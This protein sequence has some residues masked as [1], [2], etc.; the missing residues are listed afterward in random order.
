MQSGTKCGRIVETLA[1]EIAEGRY[2][3]PSSF[4]SAEQIVR[5]FKVAY[6]TAVKAHD[7]LKRRGLV[8]SVQG[9]GTYVA[10][11]AGRSVGLVVPG[12]SG[13]DF[14]PALCRSVSA[15]CQRSS[16][17]LLFADMLAESGEG[18][19][20]RLVSIARSFVDAGV[21]GVLFHPV[22]FCADAAEAN[23]AVAGVL[24]EAGVP[25]VLIDCDIVEAPEESGYDVVGIDNAA[26]GL[27]MGE[28]VLS[29]GAARILFVSVFAAHSPNVQERLAG[30]RRA[31]SGKRG[32]RVSTFDIPQGDDDGAALRAAIADARPDAVVCSSDKVA[33]EALRALSALGL[34]VPGDV[35]LCGVNDGDFARVLSPGLTTIHQPCDD[36][37][38][39]A[40]EALDRRRGDPDA[41]PMRIFLPAP[42]VA[43]ESTSRVFQKCQKKA[44]Q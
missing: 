16:R 3:A 26:A 1:A 41:P 19:A 21:G 35:M 24:R 11:A 27:R 32:A 4:P 37:A 42:L 10:R 17:P 2:R 31:V 38:R 5:R 12:W 29:R 40:V 22:D 25:M 30:L 34:R 7:E 13:S 8:Y 43:R 23:R 39:V 33:T 20:A 9:A 15:V 28:H 44:R 18:L 36:I 6:L 14:F